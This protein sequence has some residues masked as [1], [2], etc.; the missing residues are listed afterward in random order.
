MKLPLVFTLGLLA[1]SCGGGD[2]GKTKEIPQADAC[3][4]AAKAICA[5]LFSCPTDTVLDLAKA[6]LGGDA[7]NCRTTIQQN[8][9]G[10]L[11]CAAGQTYHSDKAGMCKDQFDAATCTELSGAIR[12]TL[13]N[14]DALIMTLAPSCNQVCS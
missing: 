6:S 13:G 1:L 12:T 2:G 4:E 11:M 5:K 10:S 9:C 7:A 3:P 8:N 14:V